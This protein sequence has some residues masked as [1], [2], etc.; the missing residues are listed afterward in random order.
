MKESKH[1]QIIHIRNLGCKL[2]ITGGLQVSLKWIRGNTSLS[3][4]AIFV[5]FDA[6]RPGN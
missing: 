5:K 4:S 6:T 1:G 3:C 2:I